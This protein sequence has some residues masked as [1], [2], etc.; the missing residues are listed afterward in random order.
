MKSDWPSAER[1]IE[2]M[3]NSNG[4][5]LQYKT[6]LNWS[7]SRSYFVVKSILHMSFNGEYFCAVQYLSS[8]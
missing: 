6:L 2:S 7:T 4:V 8:P 3:I 5:V 1:M